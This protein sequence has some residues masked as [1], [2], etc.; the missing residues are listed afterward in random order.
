MR[1]AFQEE[2]D[3]FLDKL[4]MLSNLA[5]E[6][7]HKATKAFAEHDRELA[8]E[9]IEDDLIINATSA[10]IERDA[11][12]L[13][14][15]QQPVAGD[16]RRIFTVLLANSDVE[17][18]AEHAV[19]IARTVIRRNPDEEKIKRL[20]GIISEM[21][22]ITQS[23][24]SDVIKALVNQDVEAAKEIARRDELVDNLQREIY[25]VAARR[26][27]KDTDVIIGGINYIGVANN[28]ERIGDYVTNICERIVFLNTGDIV[29]LN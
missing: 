12:R 15:L 13:I 23:M 20:D 22:E 1:E 10:E 27:E 2:L 16:L 28:L 8:H 5:N 4:I 11:Y 18:L 7:L 29:E 24:I 3:K 9:V 26:M 19:S 14:A 17:R 25:G 6:S 21:T